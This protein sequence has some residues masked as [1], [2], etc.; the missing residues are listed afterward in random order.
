[1]IDATMPGQKPRLHRLD[2]TYTRS[3]VYFLTSCTHHRLPILAN[4]VIH[5]EFV[6]FAGAAASFHVLVGLY[7]I[8][9]DHIHLFA[10]FS[11][12]SP[13]LSQ[14]MKALRGSLAKTLRA[15]L[16]Q[17]IYWEKGFFDHVLRSEESFREK[18]EYVRQNPVRAGLVA[19]PEDWPYQGE[20]HAL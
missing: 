16:G 5:E 15:T 8:M 10:N 14:W 18:Y 13:S 1:M 11:P 9:P 20:I 4:P 17:G 6:R 12:A 2:W 3:P 7:V 19:R